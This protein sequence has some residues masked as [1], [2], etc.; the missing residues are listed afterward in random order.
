MCAQSIHVL[1]YTR[2]YMLRITRNNTMYKSKESDERSR[3]FRSLLS[4]GCSPVL[5]SFFALLS[6]FLFYSLYARIR[7]LSVLIPESA[8][9]VHRV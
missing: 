2:D 4:F 7:G 3:P 6:F 1:V 5:F 9:C 8:S